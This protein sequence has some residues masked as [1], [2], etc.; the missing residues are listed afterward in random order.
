MILL[1]REKKH[2]RPK[3]EGGKKDFFHSKKVIIYITGRTVQPNQKRQ[4][5]VYQHIHTHDINHQVVDY[6]S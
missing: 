6:F 2:I 5:A 3:V 4:E 1:S